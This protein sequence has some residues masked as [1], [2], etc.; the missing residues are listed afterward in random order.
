MASYQTQCNKTGEK[1]FECTKSKVTLGNPEAADIPVLAQH[2]SPEPSIHHSMPKQ[3]GEAE[4]VLISLYVPFFFL[5]WMGH[6]KRTRWVH[7]PKTCRR[8]SYKEQPVGRLW[9]VVM[10]PPG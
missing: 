1:Y 10:I 4:K 6:G 3:A 9:E 5:H 7:T 2:V 8:L